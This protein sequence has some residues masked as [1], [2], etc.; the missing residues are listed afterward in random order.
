MN[1]E[2]KIVDN[3]LEESDF[4][5][6]TS[7][8]KEKWSLQTSNGIVEE[9]PFLYSELTGQSFFNTYLFYKVVE[10]L[11][12]NDYILDRAYFNGQWNGRE[13]SLHIDGCDITAL[14]YM[15]PYEYGWGGFTEIM[16]EPE[17]TLVYPIPN[18]LMIFPGNIKHK[19]YSLAYQTCPLRVTLAFKINYN[20]NVAGN[21]VGDWR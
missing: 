19:G 18:R 3:F 4:N 7:F 2:I 14:I 20:P 10:Q 8:F 13:G 1:S 9:L 15:S 5:Q 16:T 21:V 6:V 11:D 12:G 17:P